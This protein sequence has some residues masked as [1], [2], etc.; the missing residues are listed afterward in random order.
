MPNSWRPADRNW[1]VAA[2]LAWITGVAVVDV[3]HERAD[4]ELVVLRRGGEHAVGSTAGPKWSGQN[5]VE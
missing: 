5:T 2:P 4:V 1:I 3:V